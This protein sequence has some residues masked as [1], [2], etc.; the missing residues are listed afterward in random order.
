[1][2]E[3]HPDGT[4]AAL[5]SALLGWYRERARPLAWRSTRDPWRILVSEIML[6]QTQAARV[7]PLWTAFCDRFPTAEACAAAPL[8]DVLVAWRGLGYNRRAVALHR[9]ARV[10]VAEHGGAVPDDL[11]AL[12]G[13]PGVGAYTARAVL[14]FAFGAAAAPVDTNIARVLHRAVA[15]ERLGAAALQRLADAAVP[16]G[17]AHDWASG[18]MDLGATVC[19]ARAPRCDTCPLAPDCAWRGRAGVPD[20]AAS[21]ARRAQRSEPFVGSDRYHRGRLVDALRRSDLPAEALPGAAGLDDA[22]RVVTIVDSLLADGLA[23]WEDGAL[24]LPG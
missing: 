11:E 23:E 4:S 8:G 18:L 20:P 3:D 24:R 7:E 21:A 16:A 1:M 14:V 13:L 17:A 2:R 19:T 9:T 5:Q 15:G 22:A 10:L 12:L 6:Q